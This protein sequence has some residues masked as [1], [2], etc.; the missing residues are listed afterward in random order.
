M[1]VGSKQPPDKVVSQQQQSGEGDTRKKTK[2]TSVP[3][4]HSPTP[5][6]TELLLRAN[7]GP[8]TTPLIPLPAAIGKSNFKN[9]F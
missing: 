2:P 4:L 3:T 7:P 8:C 5:S 6:G 1:Q 9:T